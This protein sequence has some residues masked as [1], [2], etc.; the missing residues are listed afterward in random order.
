[1]LADLMLTMSQK[2]KAKAAPKA[3]KPAAAKAAPKK[4]QTT[5]KPKAAPK[6]RAKPM[7]DDEDEDI[8]MA[9]GA[10]NDNSVLSQT[11]PSAKKQKKAPAAKK[12]TGKPLAPVENE[13][14][15]LDGPAESNLKSKTASERYQKA[16]LSEIL[17]WL[18]S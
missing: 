11:P 7:S 8:S 18:T 5:L 2:T 16:C 1:M 12:A 10:T 9:D 3:K 17:N 15:I 13:V 4:M 6:K 14:S